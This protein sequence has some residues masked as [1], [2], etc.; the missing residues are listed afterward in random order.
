VCA[1]VVSCLVGLV[2]MDVLTARG[3]RGRE[4]LSCCCCSSGAV[5]VGVVVWEEE[6]EE[7]G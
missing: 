6:K 5:A 7:E 1:R 3:W 2:S 4:A